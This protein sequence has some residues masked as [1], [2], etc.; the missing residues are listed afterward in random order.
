MTGLILRRHALTCA[1]TILAE[2]GARAWLRL[3]LGNYRTG[4]DALLGQRGS[5]AAG[6]LALGLLL[7]ALLA[8]AGAYGADLAPVVAVLR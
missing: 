7:G 1:W 8:L 2:F 4:L 6:A 5:A 3:A